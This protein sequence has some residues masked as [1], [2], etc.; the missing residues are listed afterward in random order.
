MHKSTSTDIDAYKAKRNV[1]AAH[2]FINVPGTTLNAQKIYLCVLNGFNMT[3]LF[4]N[5]CNDCKNAIDGFGRM[6]EVAM[7]KLF[8]ILVN[9]EMS[10][11]KAPTVQV[12]W[13]YQDKKSEFAF[14]IQ[15]IDVVA[16]RRTTYPTTKSLV[17]LESSLSC[18][19]TIRRRRVNVR[20]V[21]CNF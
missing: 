12:S 9:E 19:S 20:G 4:P 11:L 21:L 1:W 2:S 15:C 14:C 18:R 7:C 16:H 3:N 13:N 10:I 8:G 5:S 6:P 17:D